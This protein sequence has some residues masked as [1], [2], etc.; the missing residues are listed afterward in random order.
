MDGP[1]SED[2]LRHIDLPVVSGL[3]DGAVTADGCR[4]IAPVRVEVSNA[5][6]WAREID[7]VRS[8]AW[9]PRPVILTGVA[10][11]HGR[12]RRNGG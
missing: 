10:E 2:S 7:L 9:V 11:R 5:V 4:P 6:L 1:C 3:V 12:S 8:V